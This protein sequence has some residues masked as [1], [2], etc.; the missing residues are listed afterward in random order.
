MQSGFSLSWQY[1]EMRAL[2]LRGGHPDKIGV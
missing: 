2:N 1:I